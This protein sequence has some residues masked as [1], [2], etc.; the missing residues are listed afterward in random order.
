MKKK[1][2]TLGV[3]AAIAAGAQ[4]DV[5]INAT[6]FPDATFRSIV[7]A[8]Y[9]TNGDGTLSNTEIAAV[10]MIRTTTLSN[11]GLKTLAGI[12]NFTAL[13]YLDCY[14]NQLSTLDLSRN[15]KLWSLDCHNNRLTDIMLPD[16]PQLQNVIVY[17]NMLDCGV[18]ERLAEQLPDVTAVTPKLTDPFCFSV[19][20]QQT[21]ANENNVFTPEQSAAL[22]AKGW[23]PKG[24]AA[25]GTL[26]DHPEVV[27]LTP[28]C[29]PDGV[30]R[31]WL[32]ANKDANHDGLLSYDEVQAVWEITVTNMGIKSLEGIN[33]FTALTRL[34]CTQ[35]ELTELELSLEKLQL[36][37]C[38]TNKIAKL[39]VSKCKNLLIMRCGSN[40]LT[41]LDVTA[42]TEL[43][44]L[45]CQANQLTSL[46]VSTLPNL[47]SLNMGHNN[48]DALA[49]AEI[50]NGLPTHEGASLMFVYDDEQEGNYGS[51][52]AVDIAKSKGWTVTMYS[53]KHWVDYAGA[54]AQTVAID[55]MNFPDREFR[56]WVKYSLATNPDRDDELNE[57][58][59]AAATDLKIPSA[60][61]GI[62]DMK[63]IEHFR[64]ATVLHVPSGAFTTLDLTG[65]P[66]LEDVDVS[67]GCLTSIDVSNCPKLKKLLVQHNQLSA[68]D[69]SAN[70]ELSW[71]EVYDNPIEG[72]AL[73]DFV[74]GL[75][76][77]ENG[78]I[79]CSTDEANIFPM[80][81]AH[82]RYASGQGWEVY[83]SNAA[84][85]YYTGEPG[86]GKALK[87]DVNNDG[88]VGIGDIVAVTNI[89]A[90]QE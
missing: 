9:D 50:A 63:G 86:T 21:S 44:H 76:K 59:I 38:S 20:S 29:F 61:Y 19:R 46:D 10:K 25:D 32:A 14:G 43:A 64:C 89:M 84:E 75:P 24:I 12:E 35:N 34:Y 28:K 58:E 88:A 90:G 69:V 57:A 55:E 27:P 70:T 87:G 85:D 53:D 2:I 54:P 83:I 73:D 39:D 16:Q 6:S 41:T 71:L 45:F 52:T 8:N 80:T 78:V 33:Y 17:G 66:L 36:L 37:Q 74:F 79:T 81:T 48:F 7:S 23:V 82:V 77:V 13:E 65:N 22:K 4:A 60:W 15:T 40:Q 42:N 49:T 51:V 62:T 72:A 67:G 26:T 30:F 31:R 3:L 18:M 11:R 56:S 5:T 68:L 1:V 47:N